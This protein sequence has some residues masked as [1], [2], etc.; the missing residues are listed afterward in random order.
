MKREGKRRGEEKGDFSEKREVGKEKKR[1]KGKK[2]EVE[3]GERENRWMAR[4]RKER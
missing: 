3:E 2:R 1:K 4:E